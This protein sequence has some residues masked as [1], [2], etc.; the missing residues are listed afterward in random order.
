[1]LKEIIINADDF[2]ISEGVNRAI[3]EGNKNGIINSTS[4][5]VNLLNK[6]KPV[7]D[8]IN[9]SNI[10]FGLHLNLTNG[11][12]ISNSSEINLLVNKDRKFKNGF[13]KLFMLSLIS[14]NILKKQVEIETKAQIQKA[15]DLNLK[16]THIDSHRHIHMIPG[17]FKIIEKL[18]KENNIERIRIINENIFYTTKCKGGFSYLFDGGLIKYIILR[19]FALINNYK[20]PTYFFSILY[21]GKIFGNRIKNLKVPP[22]YDSVELGIHPNIGGIDKPKEISDRD[23]LSE[24]RIREFKMAMDLNNFEAIRE[25]NN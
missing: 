16:L 10:R 25:N 3:I 4:V 19:T 11:Y 9:T 20:T 2:G 1:M 23:V 21:T 18:A 22:K 8:F 15:K 12:S 5:M 17:L 13:V 24:N 6:D 7:E 14:P